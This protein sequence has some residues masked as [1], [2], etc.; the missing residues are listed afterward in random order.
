MTLNT[1]TS[2]KA[3]GLVLAAAASTGIGAAAV[4]YP[5]LAKWATEKHLQDPW[6][7]QLE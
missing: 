3:F 4:F 2:V 5:P 6:D 1:E 7:S